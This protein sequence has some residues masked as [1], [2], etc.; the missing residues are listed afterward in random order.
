MN[1]IT[2]FPNPLQPEQRD[3]FVDQR[4]VEMFVHFRSSDIPYKIGRLI[5]QF[6]M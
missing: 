6:A 5:G 2:H 1:I 4:L 3:D